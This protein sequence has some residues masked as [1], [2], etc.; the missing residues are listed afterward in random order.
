MAGRPRAEVEQHAQHLAGVVLGAAHLHHV[1]VAG[2][3]ARAHLRIGLEA[4]RTRDHRLGHE[5]IAAVRA[6]HRHAFDPAQIAQHAADR[7]LEADLDAEALGD[8]PPLRELTGP[9]TRHVDRDAALEIALAVDLGM[10][11]Q[12]L[13]PDAGLTHP[14]NGR[15]R[16]LDQRLRQLAVH[17]ALGHAVEIGCK[18]VSAVGRDAPW[19]QTAPRQPPE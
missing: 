14:V 16:L 5:I 13:P 19:W 1:G 10:L 4:A 7:R 15:I 3:V 8:L 6:A 11:L 18:I 17:A 2:E 12:R 9:A